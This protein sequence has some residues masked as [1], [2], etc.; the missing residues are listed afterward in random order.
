MQHMARRD[1][2][3]R[4]STMFSLIIKKDIRAIGL[5]ELTFSHAA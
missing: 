1:I 3:T 5:K 4:D 2:F